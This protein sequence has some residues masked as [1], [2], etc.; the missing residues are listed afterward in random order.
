MPSRLLAALAALALLLPMRPAADAIEHPPGYVAT[1]ASAPVA[2]D[3]RLDDAAWKDTPW[4]ADFVDIEG[5]AKP[6]PAL[7]T[8]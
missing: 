1:R 2:I 4:T 7:R 8:G 3:G 5:G 6:R